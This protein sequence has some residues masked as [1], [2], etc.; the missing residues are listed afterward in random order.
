MSRI[1]F[2]HV[3][4]EGVLHQAVAIGSG[5]QDTPVYTTE[6]HQAFTARWRF[7]CRK[8]VVEGKQW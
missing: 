3:V 5:G 8:T 2:R 7:D 1:E 6:S 4:T